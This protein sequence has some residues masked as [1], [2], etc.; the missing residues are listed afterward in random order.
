MIE[1]SRCTKHGAQWIASLELNIAAAL[2]HKPIVEVTAP[3]LLAVLVDLQ[4]RVAE[5]AIRVRQRL[6]A[7]FEDAI[8]HGLTTTNPVSTIRPQAA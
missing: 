1:G 2:W 4:A 5:T 7:I 3:E 6:D 8:F